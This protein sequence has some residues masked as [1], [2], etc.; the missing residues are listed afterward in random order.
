[1]VSTCFGSEGLSIIRVGK[2]AIAAKFTKVTIFTIFTICW[3]AIRRVKLACEPVGSAIL[4][5]TSA[6]GGDAKRV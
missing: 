3:A 6:G 2:D 5:D 1:M 4:S